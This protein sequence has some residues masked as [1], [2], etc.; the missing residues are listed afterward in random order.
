[1]PLSATKLI[2]TILTIGAFVAAMST[3]APARAGDRD[4]VKILLGTAATLY[5]LHEI[6]KHH[7]KKEKKKQ[8][9]SA[10]SGGKPKGH[11][12]GHYGGKKGGKKKAHKPP[13]PRY[14]LRDTR[15]QGLVMGARCLNRNYQAAGR[16][17]GACQTRS[18]IKGR[19]RTVYDYGCLRNRG[20]RLA[21][22]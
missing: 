14:C 3:A 17:P 5:L 19:E 2:T 10:H 1:M 22:H 13:L 16:L 18:W 4:G 11:H 6:D 21:R 12:G 15:H 8:A 7:K 9:H 20:Y